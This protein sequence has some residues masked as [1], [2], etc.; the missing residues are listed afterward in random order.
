MSALK[1][2]GIM[3]TEDKRIIDIASELQISPNTV[4]KYLRGDRTSRPIRALVEN[5]LAKKGFKQTGGRPAP[6]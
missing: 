3:E 2:K 5:Y 1:L 4:A 6:G